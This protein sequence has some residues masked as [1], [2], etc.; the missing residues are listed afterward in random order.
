[1]FTIFGT[2]SMATAIDGVLSAGGALSDDEL[3][4]LRRL[5]T[6]LAESVDACAD[7]APNAAV[8]AAADDGRS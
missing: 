1:T 2:G 5:A 8:D 4:E 6:K 3:R 7:V